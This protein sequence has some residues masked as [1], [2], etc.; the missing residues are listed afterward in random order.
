MKFVV[1]DKTFNICKLSSPV[2]ISNPYNFLSLTA[3]SV[4]LVCPEEDTP[5]N[6]IEIMQ[7]WSCIE[8]VGVS[9]INESGI[10]SSLSKILASGNIPIY[11]VSTFDAVFVFID[12]NRIINA[13]Q[14]LEANGHSIESLSY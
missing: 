2:I 1:L 14:L 8:I 12:S 5:D 13:I 10:I 9:S 3:D 4:T 6:A 7:T 11:V